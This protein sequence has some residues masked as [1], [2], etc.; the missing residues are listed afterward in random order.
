MKLP[1]FPDHPEPVAT[2]SIVASSARC[3]ACEQARGFIYVGPTYGLG[4]DLSEQ[5]L[6]T[7]T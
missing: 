5:R 4:E 2:G 7:S 1:D 6:P 3:R